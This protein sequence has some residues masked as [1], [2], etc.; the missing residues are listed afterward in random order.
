MEG[1]NEMKQAMQMS[2]LLFD[3][4]DSCTLLSHNLRALLLYQELLLEQLA[5]QEATR[6]I[7]KI[8]SNSNC[9]TG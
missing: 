5:N 1:D 2:E 8:Q 9:Q 7:Q 4:C 3:I 6:A